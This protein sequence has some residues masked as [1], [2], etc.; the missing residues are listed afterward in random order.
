MRLHR[1]KTALSL[2]TFV[3]ACSAGNDKGGPD[4]LDG[5]VTTDSGLSSETRVDD[6]G[7]FL[8]ALPET[9]PTCGS[10][11]CDKDGYKAVDGDCNDLDGTINPE[12]FD[13]LADTIDNDCNGTVDDPVANCAAD[14]T[15]KDAIQVVRSMDMCKQK[16]RTKTGAVFDALTKAEWYST[17]TKGITTTIVPGNEHGIAVG[18][19]SVF[20][21][22]GPRNGVGML[23]LQSGP[24]LGKDP[25]ASAWMDGGGAKIAD[26]CAAIPLN[27][28]DCKSLTNG[29]AAGTPTPISDYT[30][31]R[32][33]IQV[34]SNAQAMTFDFSF[35]ST[36]FNQYWHSAYNDAFFAIVTTKKFTTNVA[37]DATGSAITVNSG[38][39][40]LCPLPPGPAGI[41]APEALKNCVGIAGDKT[42]SIF[43]TLAGTNFDGTGI[44]KTDDTVT[45]PTS[46]KKFIYGGGSGWLTT[47][48]AVE[49]G[50]TITLRLMIMDTSD[51]YLDSG[52]LIDNMSWEKAPPKIATGDTG[53]PPA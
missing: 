47:K 44:G 26:G 29:T 18:I 36:E 1:S 40:Q 43:G 35:L 39:F 20:G 7:L 16:T 53:R 9:T 46:G 3:A 17:K 49:P 34:P 4:G 21:S 12:A 32:L 48:F 28:D 2:V 6:G 8:D 41:I 24:V 14:P 52:A 45:D 51:G 42:K 19:F 13:F 27:I 50:E 5:G 25:R 31:L 33:T 22:N 10:D 30:E 37:K 11:D 38:F 23:A 15:S